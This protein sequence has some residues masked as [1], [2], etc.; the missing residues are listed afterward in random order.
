MSAKEE[1]GV[2][3]QEG[4][5]KEGG[6]ADEQINLRVQASDQTEVFFKIKKVTALKK[7]MD[8]YCQRQSINPNSIRFLYDGQRLQQERTPKDY[9]MENNDIIDVVIEQ[10]GGC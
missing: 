3:K 4:E 8:A 1:P 6:V 10:V 5:K 2:P 7:L 9:N